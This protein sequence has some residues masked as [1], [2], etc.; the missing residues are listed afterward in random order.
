M[1]ENQRKWLL[2]LQ[3]KG[4]KF[5]NVSFSGTIWHIGKWE[6]KNDPKVYRIQAQ[7]IPDIPDWRELCREIQ[8]NGVKFKM[9]WGSMWNED[10]HDFEKE[11]DRYQ[12]CEQP[13]PEW[14][15]EEMTEETKPDPR[16]EIP[17]REQQIQWYEDMLHHLRTGEPM[18]E[19]EFRSVNEDGDA[20]SEWKLLS[21]RHPSWAK[22]HEY[23][24]KPRTVTYWHCVTEY[25]GMYGLIRSFEGVDSLQ[26]I[27][28]QNK[29]RNSTTKF[30]PVIETTVEIE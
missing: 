3:D 13:L 16:E 4:I 26:K 12:I 20:A 22:T 7:P 24:R 15:N 11:R 27:V 30:S 1:T 9:L 6:F 14:S 17:H 29:S 21:N 2:D 28:D 10:R 25:E 8:S 19:Y 5:E 18:R 23:R